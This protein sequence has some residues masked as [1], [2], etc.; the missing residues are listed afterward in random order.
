MPKKRFALP[1][2]LLIV[3]Q[4]I[5][6]HSTLAQQGQINRQLQ[7]QI[8]QYANRMKDNLLLDDE[9]AAKFRQMLNQRAP[10][11]QALQQRIQAQPFAPQLQPDILR[12]QS[13]VRADLT[14]LLTE[15]QRPKLTGVDERL[16]FLQLP[17]F[18]LIRVPARERNASAAATNRTITPLPRGTGKLSDA[19]R[20]VHILNRLTYG[21]RPGDVE[22]VLQIGL[23]RFI[24]EQLNPENI[25]DSELEK[26]LNVL[27]TLRMTSAEL[28]QYYPPIQ[29]AEQRARDRNQPSQPPV[30]GRP[31][32]I[33]GEL[34]QQ[35]LVRAVSSNRQLQEIMTDFWFNHFNVLATKDADLWQV[36]SYERDAIRPRA[37][38]KFRDLL[39]AVSQS[40]AMLFYL[41][42]W[43]SVAP[44]AQLPRPQLTP[45]TTPGRPPVAQGMTSAPGANSGTSTNSSLPAVSAQPDSA[46]SASPPPPPP[47]PTQGR[48]PGL[49]ENF[50]RELLELHTMGVDGGYTQNDVLNVAR[51]FTGW[52]IS[53]PVQGGTFMFRPWAHDTGTKKVLNLT[54][55]EHG[56]VNDGIRVIE[57]LSRH[58]STAR[59]IAGKLCKRFVSDS[60]PPKLVEKLAQVFLETDGNIADV[61]RTLF[62]SNDFNSATAFRSKIKS[63]L[64]LAAS[65][66]RALDGDT[67]GAPALHEWLRRMGEPLYQ[68]QPPTGYGEA[69][70]AKMNT[71]VFLNRV[72]FL[73]ALAN[74]QIPG[75]SFASA[76][77]SVTSLPSQPDQLQGTLTS[78]VLKTD[79]SEA[80]RKAI[81]AGLTETA[82]APEG[83]PRTSA[84]TARA[85]TNPQVARLLSLLLA[86]SEFQRR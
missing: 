38:G 32:Q 46:K 36:T 49:N 79:A 17:N 33:L 76:S 73:A 8:D 50:A 59:F 14:S 84:Q 58:P 4:S 53:Q 2:I 16:P 63:P 69:T 64:E 68:C 75:T 7:N 10:G 12:E 35:K 20:A 66:I 3:L 43:V 81:L 86:S 77:L 80:T 57:M 37:L 51:C 45:R 40:P 27:P 42:N 54:I 11:F 85:S 61:L 1:A 65:A 60:P 13:A 19:Q 62:K 67:D 34:Q 30:M 25:D 9:Q 71:G 52:T 28:Y 78:A 23:D 15:S 18:Y 39:L 72:S 21:P 6:I 31:N 83:S 47:R 5:A 55:Q 41:D 74:N 56:G 29:V 70:S 48:R 24:D 26:R 44:G 22:R 82:S